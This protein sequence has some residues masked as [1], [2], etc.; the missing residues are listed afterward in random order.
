MEPNLLMRAWMVAHVY[1]A[2]H[3]A[4]VCCAGSSGEGAFRESLGLQYTSSRHDATGLCTHYITGTCGDTPISRIY[5][6]CVGFRVAGAS[7]APCA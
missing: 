5:S 4:A 1:G 3:Q 6:G 2:K 7:P